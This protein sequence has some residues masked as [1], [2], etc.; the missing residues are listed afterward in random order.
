MYLREEFQGPHSSVFYFFIY[1]E[2]SKAIVNIFPSFSNLYLSLSPHP[3]DNQYLTLF[4]SNVLVTVWLNRSLGLS[5]IFLVG[6]ENDIILIF[7]YFW[8]H[9]YWIFDLSVTLLTVRS[10]HW[11]NS[12]VTYADIWELDVSVSVLSLLVAV[13]EDLYS[14]SMLCTHIWRFGA[15]R[16]WWER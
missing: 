7:T 3:P 13:T 5:F 14:C 10:A 6:N 15:K 11:G 4:Y 12:G 1:Q 16:H 2:C 9:V 8:L